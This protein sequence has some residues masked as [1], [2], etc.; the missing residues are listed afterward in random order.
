MLFGVLH[1][2]ETRVLYGFSNNV[3]R[4]IDPSRGVQR[5]GP[6]HPPSQGERRESRKWCSRGLGGAVFE[7]GTVLPAPQKLSTVILST[8]SQAKIRLQTKT[9]SFQPLHHRQ[10]CERF[11]YMPLV[12]I[13][14]TSYAILDN[15]LS[16]GAESRSCSQR[17]V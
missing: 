5:S 11:N 12:P 15:P 7:A 16:N 14:E 13:T 6:E 3:H 4:Y 17:Q 1:H 8:E 9:L 2:P 10:K